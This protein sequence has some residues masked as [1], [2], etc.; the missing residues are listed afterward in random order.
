MLQCV[1]F[2]VELYSAKPCTIAF[3]LSLGFSTG[4]QRVPIEQL[5]FCST[6]FL[7]F[8][9]LCE[10]LPATLFPDSCEY[11]KTYFSCIF[12]IDV[13]CPNRWQRVWPSRTARIIVFYSSFDQLL[14]LLQNNWS[15]SSTA[16]RS[17]CGNQ[18][19]HINTMRRTN[20]KVLSDA[21]STIIWSLH[22]EPLST[23]LQHAK[24]ERCKFDIFDS[25]QTNVHQLLPFLECRSVWP[26]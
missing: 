14:I 26:G 11:Y 15:P 19:S 1:S 17:S 10:P 22:I 2:S 20:W 7:V 9:I 8:R 18:T 23:S 5:L 6:P 3:S 21:Q 24:I 25:F 16:L 13:I 12:E 4:R